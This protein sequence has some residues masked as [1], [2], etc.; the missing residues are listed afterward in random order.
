[1]PANSTT[2][3]GTVGVAVGLA[4][5]VG[6]MGVSVGDTNVGTGEFVVADV[7]LDDD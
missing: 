3:A 6:G 2:D 1:M 7:G 5:T 4:V